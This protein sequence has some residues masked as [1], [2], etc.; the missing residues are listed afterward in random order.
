MRRRSLAVA[1]CVLASPLGAAAQQA[2]APAHSE[3]IEVTGTNIRRADSETGL[4]VQVITRDDMERAGIQTAQDLVDRISAHQSAAG[5]NDAKGIGSASG[6]FSAASL[7]GLGSDKTLVLLNGR[8]LAPYALSLGT[9]IDISSIPM[10]AIERVE[11]L[12]D[13]ASAVYGTDAIGG[14][15]NFILRK[16]FTGVEVAGT[17]LATQ[18]GGGGSRRATG[19][20]GYGDLQRDGFNAFLNVDYIDQAALKA[21]ER[22]VSRTSY[23]P[24]LGF[25]ATSSQSFPANITQRVPNG[26]GF[27]RPR[28]PGVPCVPPCSFPTEHSPDMCRFDYAAVIDIVPPS[29]KTT[30]LFRATKQLGGDHQLFLEASRYHA[31][32]RYRLSPTPVSSDFAPDQPPFILPPASPFYPADFV[33]SQPGGDPTVPIRLNYRL[34]E[35]GPRVE[36]GRVD[37]DRVVVGMQGSSGPWDYQGGLLYSA[38]RE[39]TSIISGEVSAS[40]LNQVLRTGLVNPF[41]FNTPE[42]LDLVRGTQVTGKTSENRATNSSLDFKA[43]RDLMQLAAGPLA[44]ALGLEARR[45]TLDLHNEPILY[46]GDVLGGNGPQP[47]LSEA[48]RKI[49]S[50][51]AEANLP[52]VKGLEANLA[53]RTD[54][55]SD[56]GTTTNP[57]ATLRW[58]AAK[59]LLVRASAGTGF[60][61]PSLFDI[62]QPPVITGVELSADNPDPIRCPVTHAEDDCGD[63]VTPGD[64]GGNRSLKPE[65]SRQANLGF[66]LESSSGWSASADY[67]WVELTDRIDRPQLSFDSSVRAPPDAQYPGLPGPVILFIGTPQNIDTLRSSGVDVDVRYRTAPSALG[68]FSA[69]LTGTYIA[70]YERSG[71][72]I[73]LPIGPGHAAAAGGAIS[74]WRHFLALDWTRGPWGATVAQNFQNGY[75]EADLLSCD[76]NFANCGSRRVGSAETWDAQL[77]WEGIRNLKLTFGV[78]NLFDRAPPVSSQSGQSFQAGYDPGYGDP[79]GRTWYGGVRYSFK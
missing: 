20:V 71:E 6:S 1:A 35:L 54:S 32:F 41:G 45:E 64:T 3:K 47:T 49:W 42:A 63:R 60:R 37:E 24:W 23:I 75:S 72:S 34:V 70:R 2:I 69:S 36:D 53:I 66:V 25:D 29:E 38:N 55:Y 26:G 21:S 19:T 50:L 7:R 78:Y 57:K 44:I 10:G 16:D 56:F 11:V 39:T 14:V 9:T 46:T 52:I 33:R 61:A 12:K 22:E 59:N 48:S 74:R 15:I 68:R 76:E 58:Q 51:Y 27:R 73:F 67:Y 4:P 62:F 40:A 8:R 13:G 65:H 31:Y 77:R 17:I 28:N 5:H 79:R 18:Q 30:V 43:S